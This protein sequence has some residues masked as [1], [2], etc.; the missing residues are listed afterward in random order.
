MNATIGMTRH[1]WLP[2]EQLGAQKFTIE[3]IG[4]L[5]KSLYI[6]GRLKTFEDSVSKVRPTATLWSHR[7]SKRI[8]SS[9]L[10]TSKAKAT[11]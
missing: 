7:N 2:S 3:M 4:S 5:N 8:L 1:F 10:P 9:K 6:T 11:K